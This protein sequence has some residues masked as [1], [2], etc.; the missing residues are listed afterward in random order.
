MILLVDVGNTNIVLGVHNGQEYIASWRI[1]SDGNKTSDE[2][3]IQ[4]M[5]LFNVSEID[6]K[7]I[8][9]V[10]V[11][12]VVPNIMHSLENM[13]RKCFCH[14]PIIVGPGIKTGI[15]IKYDNPK[16]VGADRIV[17]AVAAHEIYKKS[18]IIIDFGTATTFCALRKNGDYLG[19][20]ICPGIRISADA[21]FERAAKLPRVE[22]EVPKTIICKSTVTSMQAGILFGY[23][24]QVEYIV[25]KMK[26]EIKNS[27]N[28]EEPLVIATG[29]LANLIAKQTDFIDI[30]DS[31]LTLE[32]L[33][34]L[35]EKNKE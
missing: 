4:V 27:K 32:G 20:C 14:E 34:I 7:E 19:G 11:S 21:L 23:I 6:P 24:G 28:K 18:A 13:L 12:S 35:Y 30:V 16:E 26:E 8:K 2:Y 33:K 17:N 15:N 5:Q 25:K 29:G 1:S 31:D 22:L 9:G 10:I 3:S